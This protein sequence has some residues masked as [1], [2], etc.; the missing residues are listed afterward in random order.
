MKKFF[1]TL[2][3]ATFAVTPIFAENTTLLNMQDTETIEKINDLSVFRSNIINDGT[4]S[5]I[6]VKNSGNFKQTI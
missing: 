3:V 1:I 2:C 6:F 5:L 4:V